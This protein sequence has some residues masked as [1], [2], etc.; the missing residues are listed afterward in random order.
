MTNQPPDD[1]VGRAKAIF[2]DYLGSKQRMFN[3][4]VDQEYDSYAV[5][6]E[7]EA[8]WRHE[9]IEELVERLSPDDVE[10][11]I[12]LRL[13]DATEVVPRLL[14]LAPLGDSYAQLQYADALWEM[15]RRCPWRLGPELVEQSKRAAI[16]RWRSVAAS[17]PSVSNGRLLPEWLSV[18]GIREYAE[19]RLNNLSQDLDPLA[20]GYKPPVMD[21]I[22][23]GLRALFQRTRRC[24][25]RLWRR[26]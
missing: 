1:R 2:R 23:R 19:K 9:L 24:W 21:V 16:E 8:R 10:A 17:R 11:L 12:S 15:A 25:E 6:A 13:M 7:Q 3:D 14:E 22:D 4:G 26:P 18:D 20:G 5:T